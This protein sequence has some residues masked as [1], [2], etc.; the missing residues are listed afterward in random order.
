MDPEVIIKPDVAGRV[1][2]LLVLKHAEVPWLPL[3][4][5]KYVCSFIVNRFVACSE[6]DEEIDCRGAWAI[7]HDKVFCSEP[8]HDNDFYK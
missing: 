6:C 3:D 7:S 1:W 4:M 5:R 8:C 2:F